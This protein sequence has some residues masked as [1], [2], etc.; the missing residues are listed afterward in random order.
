[1]TSSSLTIRQSTP[2]IVSSSC[3]RVLSIQKFIVSMATN[4]A[5]EHCWWTACCSPG[6][7]LARKTVSAAREASESFGS[8]SANTL[9]SVCSVCRTFGSRS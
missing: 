7:M 1:L 2:A 6:W 8:K 5:S 9:R 3:P 4:F